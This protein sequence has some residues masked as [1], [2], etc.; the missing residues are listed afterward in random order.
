MH[1]S[2]YETG[3]NKQDNKPLLSKSNNFTSNLKKTR[4]INRR[5]GMSDGRTSVL[6][7]QNRRTTQ[8]KTMI[9]TS[10]MNK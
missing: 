5:S 7:S 6:W 2:D 10:A 4:E 9:K 3:D 1:T 8:R